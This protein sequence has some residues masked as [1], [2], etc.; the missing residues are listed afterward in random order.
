MCCTMSDMPWRQSDLDLRSLVADRTTERLTKGDPILGWTG[1][2]YLVLTFDR[3]HECWELF[4]DVGGEVFLIARKFGRLDPDLLIQEL[5]K[6]DSQGRGHEPALDAILAHND[7]L[8]R[9]REQEAATV[10]AEMMEHL[11]FASQKDGLV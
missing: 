1:D 6:R 8:E 11:V 4:R 3:V 9:V 2:P 10:R 7:H 5:V